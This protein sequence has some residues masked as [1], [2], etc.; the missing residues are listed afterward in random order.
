MNGK[1]GKTEK[2]IANII[3]IAILEIELKDTYSKYSKNLKKIF[4]NNCLESIQHR[5]KNP[6]L[7]DFETYNPQL[8]QSKN[9]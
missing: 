5:L 3:T 7:I 4:K 6:K 8:G 2:C 1:I 9:E